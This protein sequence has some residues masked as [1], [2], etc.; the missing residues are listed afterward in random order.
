MLRNKTFAPEFYSLI[1]NWFDIREQDK[2]ENLLQESVSGASSFV[3]T[4]ICLPRHA[5]SPD[6]QSNWLSVFI[7]NSALRTPIGLFHIQLPRRVLCVYWLGYVFRERV[8]GAS[9]LVC[10]GLNVRGIFPT[11]F[12]RQMEATELYIQK[13]RTYA[14]TTHKRKPLCHLRSTN[15]LY[16]KLKPEMIRVLPTRIT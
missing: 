3:C 7:H 8:S 1:S 4:E 11:I 16:Y 15:N 2:G 9:S 6:K 12:S 5:V 13:K 10:T 14:A